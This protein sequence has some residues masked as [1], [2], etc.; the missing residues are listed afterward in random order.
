MKLFNREE[1]RAE[2]W[3]RTEGERFLSSA[4]GGERKRT[5]DCRELSGR[6][7]TH[8][9]D[10]RAR[11]QGGGGR[12]LLLLLSLSLDIR[13]RR[14]DRVVGLTRAHTHTHTRI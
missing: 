1:A 6:R 8:W 13:P 12:L 4:A 11:I 10:F 7:G 5:G 9:D 2:E 3:A 14:I